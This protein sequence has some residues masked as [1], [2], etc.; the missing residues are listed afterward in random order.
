MEGNNNDTVRVVC[1][2]R[3]FNTHQAKTR[4]NEVDDKGRP[5]VGARA[6]SAAEEEENA[7]SLSFLDDKTINLRVPAAEKGSSAKKKPVPYTLDRMFP[8]TC[9]QDDVFNEVAALTVK[10]VLDGYNGTIFAYGQTG[11]GKTH[12]MFGVRGGPPELRGLIPRAAHAIFEGIEKLDDVVEVTITCS[13]LEIY[14]EQIRDLLAPKNIGL[15]VRETPNGD[16][17][18]QGLSDEFVTSPDELLDVVAEGDKARS[19]AATNMNET[20]SRS[21]SVLIVVVTQKCRDGSVKVGKLNLADLAGSERIAHTGATGQT[22]EEA[23]KINQSLSSLG[24][25]INALTDSK[26]THIP[27]RDS[28]LTYLLKDSLGGNTKTTLLIC[29]SSDPYNGLETIS[30]LK[31]GMRA[32]NVKNTAK[33]NKQKSVAELEAMVA[34]LRGE[35]LT[36][37]KFNV[38]LRSLIIEMHAHAVAH[39][40]GEGAPRDPSA[41]P[42]PALPPAGVAAVNT[43]I[44]SLREAAGK[45]PLQLTDADKAAAKAAASG[46]AAAAPAAAA[47][48]KAAGESETKAADDADSSAAAKDDAGP[49]SAASSDAAAAAEPAAKADKGESSDEVL[50]AAWAD[51]EGDSALVLA[52]A[53][54]DDKALSAAGT[55]TALTIEALEESHKDEV[56]RYQEK[57]A[58]AEVRIRVLETAKLNL[59]DDLKTVQ[60]KLHELQKQEELRL[61]KTI[62]D[63]KQS[64]PAVTH[65]R[66][67]SALAKLCGTPKGAAAPAL[68]QPTVAEGEEHG[69]EDDEYG[70]AEM[71]SPW[72]A[73]G[74]GDAHDEDEEED[75]VEAVKRHA[76][77]LTQKMGSNELSMEHVA[78]AAIRDQKTIASLVAKNAKLEKQVAEMKATWTR[79]LDMVMES[80]LSAGNETKKAPKIVKPVRAKRSFLT[81]GGA[82]GARPGFGTL[83]RSGTLSSPLASPF[84][85]KTLS[86]TSPLAAASADGAAAD[87]GAVGEGDATAASA[88]APVTPV[89]AP[90][91]TA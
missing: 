79:Y 38:L 55:A 28:T 88:D 72:G 91:D 11:S 2:F 54:P 71:A 82:G 25:C 22:L 61:Q 90:A 49:E 21:H 43:A 46:E 30:T 5:V 24:N 56:F 51:G 80:Q 10:D 12:T 68:P 70:S 76:E 19:V 69:D 86:L 15:K 8:P 9:S 81:G 40:Y 64:A 34:H 60:E 37:S 66:S 67:T 78:A 7:F 48:T 18:V 13:F 85:P 53:E 31:F 63:M 14:R 17:Y 20:S 73:E 35:L 6:I 41:G 65:T 59:E 16:V 74:E 57:I 27:Y 52:T 89:A 23:K 62:M 3:P 33:V 26:R 83:G 77:E 84:S 45:I 39:N 75:D 1:R 47:A 42:P 36:A 58:E 32:K 50:S 4:G 29:C 87:A 44:D